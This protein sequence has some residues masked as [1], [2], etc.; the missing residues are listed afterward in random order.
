MLG[1]EKSL[2]IYNREVSKRHPVSASEEYSL[3]VRARK[4]DKIARAK[5][6]ESNL[7]FVITVVNG[8]RNIASSL[9]IP[10]EDLIQEGNY[11]MIR[12]IDRY[13]PDMGFKFITYAVWWI[14]QSVLTVLQRDRPLIFPLNLADDL[15]II[16]RALEL[17]DKDTET[18]SRNP[19]TYRLSKMTSIS[20][21][22]ITR[23][24]SSLENLVRLD[25]PIQEDNDSSLHSLIPDA[26]QQLQDESLSYSELK[27]N[28]LKSLS[29]LLPREAQIVEEYFGL[30]GEDPKTLNSIGNSLG[31]TRERV[32]QIKKRAQD[33]LRNS[34]RNRNNN[35]DRMVYADDAEEL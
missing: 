16:N 1:Y 9:D 21:K 10:I 28:I 35:D 20:E 3:A 13:N 33:K 7:R 5:L 32:R 27:E 18:T 31:L 8:Y 24:L 19:D 11:G 25:H 4:G 17:L 22:R 23:A 12:A 14:R 26:S 34:F 29:S 30:Y 6:I 2:S 15:I